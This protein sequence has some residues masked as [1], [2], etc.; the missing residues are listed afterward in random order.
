MTE[1]TL[2]PL[3]EPWA[4]DRFIHSEGREYFI[5]DQ[6]RERDAMWAERVRAALAA[7]EAPTIHEH[8]LLQQVRDAL[9]ETDRDCDYPLIEQIDASLSAAPASP[10]AAWKTVERDGVPPC[11]SETVYV[12]I[13]TA[14]FSCCF[15]EVTQDGV[16]SM[17]G[18]ELT[19]IQMSALR[20]WRELDLPSAPSV[21][22]E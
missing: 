8:D 13:N 18:P 4:I 14:G 11:N 2:P 7:R 22:K 6:I 17:A 1:T 5:A 19:T 15:N 3:P 10:I 9:M 16:C 12:G 20:Y 21:N